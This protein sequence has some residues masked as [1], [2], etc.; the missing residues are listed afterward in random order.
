[1]ATGRMVFPDFV[2]CMWEERAEFALSVSLWWS[3]SSHRRTSTGC[4]VACVPALS[5]TK[6]PFT[7]GRQ[8]PMDWRGRFI[9]R[10][11]IESRPRSQNA[12][13][14]Q[15]PAWRP[16][17][18]HRRPRSA[19]CVAEKRRLGRSMVHGRWRH[20]CHPIVVLLAF[21]AGCPCRQRQ[22][23]SGAEPTEKQKLFTS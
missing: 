16:R 20:M 10:T 12:G 6:K 22:S 14:S 18:A 17:K 21:S 23:R 9:R 8:P 13:A 5:K 7:S 3:F 19:A 11:A 15:L 2:V 1:M 4:H